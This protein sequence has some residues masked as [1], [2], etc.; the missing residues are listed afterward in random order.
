[1]LADMKS[2]KFKIKILVGSMSDEREASAV[3]S[4]EAEGEGKRAS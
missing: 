4:R 2:E 1:M 3:S